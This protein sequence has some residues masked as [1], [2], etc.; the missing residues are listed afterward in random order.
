[1]DLA[2]E[3]LIKVTVQLHLFIHFF[4]CMIVASQTEGG[5]ME[6]KARKITARY[7]GW[8]L[9]GRRI[10]VGDAFIWYGSASKIQC[11]RCYES[12]HLSLVGAKS[13]YDKIIDRIRAIRNSIS[14]WPQKI[15]DEYH[16]LFGLLMQA[17]ENCREVKLFLQE[18]ARC[19]K[20]KYRPYV[21]R[22]LKEKPCIHCGMVQ[23]IGALI[24]VDFPGHKYHCV[25]CECVA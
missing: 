15:L 12:R 16:S 18:I 1:M 22:A 14:P 25:Q 11:L 24:L 17:P 10:R 5:D 8:C 3:Y 6:V 20:Q 4:D 23:P 2:S 7:S 19:R 9:C 13:A 21:A